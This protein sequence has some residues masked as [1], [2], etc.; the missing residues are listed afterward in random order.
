MQLRAACALRSPRLTWHRRQFHALTAAVLPTTPMSDIL[1]RAV[2]Q[3]PVYGRRTIVRVVNITQEISETKSQFRARCG[4]SRPC[5]FVTPLDTGFRSTPHS[6]L[7]FA[8]SLLHSSTSRIAL[9]ASLGASMRE[10]G[11]DAQPTRRM[12]VQEYDDK[13]QQPNSRVSPSPLHQMTHACAAHILV[14]TRL[15]QAAQSRAAVGLPHRHLPC[16]CQRV[17]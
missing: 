17:R 4:Q 7:T 12:T 9:C 3:V 8:R 1:E 11:S 14:A 6:S 16:H 13:C 15:R 10:R 2:A 5:A